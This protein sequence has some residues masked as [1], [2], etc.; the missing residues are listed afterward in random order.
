M[1]IPQFLVLENPGRYSGLDEVTA[2]QFEVVERKTL[3]LLEKIIGAFESTNKAKTKFSN[4]R[5][6]KSEQTNEFN[7]GKVKVTVTTKPTTLRTDYKTVVEETEKF[8]GFVAADYAQGRLRRGVLTIDGVCYISLGDMIGKIEE[9][10]ESVLEGKEG[11]AQSV[12][13]DAPLQLTGEGLDK[14]VFRLGKDYSEPSEENA[15]DYARALALRKDITENFYNQFI[16]ALKQGTGWDNE[17]LPTASVQEFVRAGA[18]LFPVQVTPKDTPKYGKIIE[19]LVKPFNKKVSKT[20]GELIKLQ[21]GI[22]DP[23]LE[24]YAPRT[25]DGQLYIRLDTIQQ[26]LAKI[27]AELTETSCSYKIE[28]SIRI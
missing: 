1:K 20:T 27:K 25:R 19:A 12:K 24:R 22:V 2:E 3:P 8:L 7:Y 9:L 11:I 6:P 21:E 14:V 15:A 13:C 23:A 18:Y 17:H 4:E 5:R 26:R 10:K 28:R 16:K